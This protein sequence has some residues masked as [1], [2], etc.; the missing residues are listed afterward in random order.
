MYI[1]LAVTQAPVFPAEIQ[2]SQRFGCLGLEYSAARQ[3]ELSRFERTLST[4]A[5]SISITSEQH[6]LDLRPGPARG[7]AA[8]LHRLLDQVA[9]AEEHERVLRRELGKRGERALQDLVG[10]VVATHDVDGDAHGD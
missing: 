6:D 5:S 10:R 8:V 2:A 3:M 1:W 7:D 4:G 9:V